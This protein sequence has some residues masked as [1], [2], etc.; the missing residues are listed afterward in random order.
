MSRPTV[1]PGLQKQLDARGVSDER[2][3]VALADV[4]GIHRKAPTIRGYMRG[5]RHP[6]VPV[7]V[8][9]ADV[10][11]CTVEE[12]VTDPRSVGELDADPTGTDAD[13]VP[14]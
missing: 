1:I 9:I 4:H 13:V 3:C 6:G 10:L 12:L 8:A 7:V 5:D 14:A 11:G 2:L